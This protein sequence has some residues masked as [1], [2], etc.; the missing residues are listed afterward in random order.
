[1]SLARRL[2]TRPWL[3]EPARS[4][5]KASSY[6][7]RERLSQLVG[8]LL[9]HRCAESFGQVIAGQFFEPAQLVVAELIEVARQHR[10]EVFVVEAKA[11]V[12]ARLLH[13]VAHEPGISQRVDAA[14]QVAV[15]RDGL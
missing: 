4:D 8:L 15:R 12:I 6:G 11:T 13:D 2:R 10:V 3:A 14:D 1:M 7:R 9:S 5:Q